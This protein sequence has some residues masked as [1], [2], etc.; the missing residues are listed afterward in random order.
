MKF[1]TRVILIVLCLLMLIGAVACDGKTTDGGR[2]ET[3][4]TSKEAE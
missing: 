1:Y 2:R 3:E 4:D